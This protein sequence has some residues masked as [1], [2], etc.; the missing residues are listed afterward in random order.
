MLPV[1]ENSIV[2]SKLEVYLHQHVRVL[3]DLR[4]F[5]NLGDIAK[6]VVNG[7]KFD[8]EIVALPSLIFADHCILKC[9]YYNHGQ[10]LPTVR[11]CTWSESIAQQTGVNVLTRLTRFPT[12]G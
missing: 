11:F 7:D 12:V 5:E 8:G 4:F 3:D 1:V 6:L 2:T 10:R 9:I